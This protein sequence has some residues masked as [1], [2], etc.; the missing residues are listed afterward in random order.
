VKYNADGDLLF[1]AAKDNTPT[2]WYA[3]TGERLGTYEYHAGAIWDIDPSWDS[4]Y[5]LT[6]CAD[7]N[8][9]LFEVTTGNYIARMPHKGV[10]R[11]SKWGDGHQY[12]ATAADPFTSRERGTVNIYNFP[13]EDSLLPRKLSYF[14]IFFQFPHVIVSFSSC[15]RKI[16]QRRSCTFTFE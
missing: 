4:T 15:H 3:D 7:A 1:S 12:F 5:V 6:A 10:V 8:A 13:N 2:V 9:R 11:S 14:S 16:H